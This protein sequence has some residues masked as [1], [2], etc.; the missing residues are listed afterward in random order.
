MLAAA[1]FTSGLGG[2]ANCEERVCRMVSKVAIDLSLMREACCENPQQEGCDQLVMLIPRLTMLIP[3]MQQACDDQNWDRMRLIWDEFKRL[4][5]SVPYLRGLVATLCGETMVQTGENSWPLL[6]PA[7][8]VS[9][10][11]VFEPL[12]PPQPVVVLPGS[13]EETW[14]GAGSSVRLHLG[15]PEIVWEQEFVLEPGGSLHALTWLGNETCSLTGSFSLIERSASGGG[16]LDEWCA[17][18]LKRLDFRFHGEA[19][20]GSLLFDPTFPSHIILNERG[21]GVLGAAVRIEAALNS[22]PTVN[23]E[24]IAELVW[25]ELPV[26]VVGEAIVLNG[27]VDGLSLF[28]VDPFLEGRIRNRLSGW[29]SG[30][31]DDEGHCAEAGRRVFERFVRAYPGCF[32]VYGE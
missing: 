12:G 25:I 31:T 30:W 7:D 19:V 14:L 32:S 1:A 8:T 5:W 10:E 28:P 17:K 3:Q 29:A 2:C 15:T 6:L 16:S 4:P 11:G 22:D 23:A 27:E 26:A 18:E 9:F 20:S 24:G 13:L 21:E